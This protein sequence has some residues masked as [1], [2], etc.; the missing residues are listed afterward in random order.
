MT[1]ISKRPYLPA[2]SNFMAGADSPRDFLERCLAVLAEREPEIGAFVHYD[3]ER[4]RAAADASTKRWRAG[5]PL[6]PI[7]GMPLG[8]K[9]I[10]ETEDF[11]TEMG[12]PLFTG[13]RSERDAASVAALRE[14]GAVIVGKT[15]TTE[16]AA[17][18]PR[19]TR[20]PH[21]P[22]RTPGGSSSGSAAAVAAG[23]ISAGL[24]TQVIGSIIRPSSF[25][26]CIGFKP[27]V[28]AINRGGSHDGLSQSADG[29]IAA[30]LEDAWQVAYEIATRAGG[31][32]GFAGLIGPASAPPAKAPRALA[33]LETEG[34]A[35]A[36]PDARLYLEEALHQL[37]QNGIEIVR[38]EEPA[39]AAVEDVVAEAFTLSFSILAWESRWP[40]NVYRNRDASK[41]SRAMVGRLAQ[42]EAMTIDDY[43]ALLVRR[44]QARARYAELEPLCDA[45]VTLSAP[46]PAPLGL[47]STGDPRFAVPASL[48]GV[49]TL[50]L[51]VFE[52]EGMPLGLQAIGF[53]HGDADLFGYAAWLHDL[54]ANGYAE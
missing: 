2:A 17:T 31:D 48:L 4:A 24:G 29:V 25:C 53:E 37:A 36:E 23:M 8:I 1:K 20:N 47:E 28:G 45:C 44:A 10:I 5:Q 18:E 41:L 32:P 34:W 11:P 16:F 27:T 43:R 51:P 42:A 15:V 30:T 46:G 54:L 21:D 35:T 49:P 50:S 7:D 22:R 14:A 6:S 39:V 13:W 38:R 33:V 9:D 3:V 26:G 40:V 52:V 12:S 19:G